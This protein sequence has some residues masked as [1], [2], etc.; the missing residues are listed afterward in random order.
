LCFY[1]NNESCERNLLCFIELQGIAFSSW[2]VHQGFWYKPHQ[3]LQSDKDLKVS[4]RSFL[5]FLCDYF[6]RSKLFVDEPIAF[7]GIG[8]FKLCLW[9]SFHPHLRELFFFLTFFPVPINLLLTVFIFTC[10]HFSDF[11][12]SFLLQN[13]FFSPIVHT[14]KWR[15]IHATN[16][17]CQDMWGFWHFLVENFLRWEFSALRIFCVANFLRWLWHQQFL[18]RSCEKK[19]H[20]SCRSSFGH[21][22]ILA[23][24]HTK[25]TLSFL[26]Q[27]RLS[28]DTSKSC[29]PGDDQ[30]WG[31]TSFLFR[32]SQICRWNEI[33]VFSHW[34]CFWGDSCLKKSSIEERS[35]ICHYFKMF[36]R[37]PFHS[38][39]SGNLQL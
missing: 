5:W 29:S 28:E 10:F 14:E 2:I 33:F 8:V 34:G 19:D 17:Q 31:E 25:S 11:L 23:A 24:I 27:K 7:S 13:D 9:S 32:N 1:H 38:P 18:T 16:Q 20:A 21:E 15:V 3:M 12:T 37:K 39:F 22:S 4:V 6:L 36:L 30:D 26:E 35:W